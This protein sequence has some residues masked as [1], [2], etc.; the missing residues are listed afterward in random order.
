MK[1]ILSLVL[2]AVFMLTLAACGEDSPIKIDDILD[3]ISNPDTEECQGLIDDVTDERAAKE[4]LADT[5]V[6]NWDGDL[7][8][9]IA[10][11]DIIDFSDSMEVETEF[12]FSIMEDGENHYI[13]VVM[14]D[15]S[16][17]NEEGMILHRT[18]DLDF[19]GE[20]LLIETIF[21]EVETG[22]HVFINFAP[23]RELLIEDG[24]D[25]LID[26]L[27]ILGANE[28]WFMFKFDDS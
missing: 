9:I 12:S 25:E 20:K 23:L 2:L 19:D 7:S 10:L 15:R 28:D 22:V 8:H 17:D 11:L 24:D 1:K 21:Q 6:A 4:I 16:V 18:L 26:V 14:I 5:I 27:D 3:C 13:H